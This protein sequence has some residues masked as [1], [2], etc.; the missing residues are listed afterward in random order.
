MNRMTSAFLLAA[1][2]VAGGVHVAYAHG[3]HVAPSD[4]HAHW[5]ILAGAAVVAVVGGLTV[6]RRRG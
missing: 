1:T 4:G 5:E 6:L 2:T 3:G